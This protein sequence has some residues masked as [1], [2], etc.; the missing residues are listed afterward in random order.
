VDA[1]FA[2]F[3]EPNNPFVL[4]GSV[5]LITTA[6]LALV[7]ILLLRSGMRGTDVVRR[8]I[9]VGMA[10]FFLFWEIEWQVWHLWHGIWS[11]E[12][13]L[14]LHLCSVMI[15][16]SMYGLWFE[17]RR[18]Y[19]LMYFMGIA[20]AIQALIT[21]NAHETFPHIRFMSTM[22]THSLLVICG[23]WVIFVEKYRPTFRSARNAFLGL[24]AYALV[25]YF[26]NRAVG[27]NYLY[28]VAKPDVAT[29]MDYFPAW[30]WYIP[31]LE[32]LLV[33]IMVGMYVPFI[34]RGSGIK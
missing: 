16:V 17:D 12:I 22:F 9:R 24:N 30:P 13:N 23:F 25:V 34:R 18:V 33:I 19:P 27:A 2:H 14:P 3:P 21:P 8:R 28:V 26:I 10:A 31:I 1:I 15:W 5:H 29:L 20:G 7:G 11:A 6:L 4:F 32:G